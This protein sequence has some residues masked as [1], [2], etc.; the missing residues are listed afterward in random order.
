MLMWMVVLINIM[1]KMSLS[2][3]EFYWRAIFM[4]DNWW[5]LNLGH[6]VHI[7]KVIQ[8]PARQYSNKF[9]SQHLYFLLQV[10][11]YREK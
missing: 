3:D 6:A 10:C 5:C 2:P 8:K 7:H 1:M 9:I 4:V 11:V